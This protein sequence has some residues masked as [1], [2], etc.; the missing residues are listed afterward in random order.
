MTRGSR[1]AL[2][3]AKRSRFPQHLCVPM[4]RSRVRGGFF[5]PFP[6]Y[7]WRYELASER[8]RHVSARLHSISITDKGPRGHVWHNHGRFRDPAASSGRPN[9][10]TL[11]HRGRTLPPSRRPTPPIH[12]RGTSR[13]FFCPPQM[14]IK[15]NSG[16][17]ASAP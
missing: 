5:F 16:W 10:P 15:Q 14:K 12:R 4:W 9:V 11:V 3:Y 1:L 17:T 7:N 13:S 2:K 6:F 8:R